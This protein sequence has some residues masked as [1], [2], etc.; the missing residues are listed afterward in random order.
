MLKWAFQQLENAEIQMSIGENLRS[1][2]T[3]M[4]YKYVF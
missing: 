2:S 1:K 4:E 3:I